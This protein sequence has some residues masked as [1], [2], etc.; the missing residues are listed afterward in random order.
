MAPSSTAVDLY[1]PEFEHDACGVAFVVD[2]HGRRSHQIVR[3]GLDSLCHLEHRGASGAEV[4]TGDGAGIL[5]QIPDRFYREVAGLRPARGR[6]L[7]HRHRLPARRRAGRADA[8]RQVE[9]AGRRRGARS[10]SAGGRSRPTPRRSAASPAAPCPA[11]TRSSWPARPAIDGLDL[12]R[13]AFILRKRIEHE[14]TGI[15][16]PSLSART[17]DLQGDADRPAG[18]GLFP[19]PQRRAPRERPGPGPLPLLD[20]HLPELAARPPLPLPRPQRRDQHPAGQPQ[21][22]AGPGGP[23]APATSSPATWSGSSRSSPPAPATRPAS[24]RCSSCCTSAG[25]RSPTP[26]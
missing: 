19:R 21:L 18:R 2:M 11:S 9:Q 10:C 5:I 24:T 22:D 16:F 4:N 6:G 7:R 15:Y 1:R 12:E 8:R 17:V 20:Q 25:G 23:A 26:C 14:L 13:R 3:M